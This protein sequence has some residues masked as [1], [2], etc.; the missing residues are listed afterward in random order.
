MIRH[1]QSFRTQEKDGRMISQKDGRMEERKDGRRRMQGEGCKEKDARTEGRS[2]RSAKN[3]SLQKRM[4]NWVLV[5]SH[6]I[7]PVGSQVMVPCSSPR[8]ISYF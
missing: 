4:A 3:S 6:V 8:W 5:R 2:V 7:Q 1:D